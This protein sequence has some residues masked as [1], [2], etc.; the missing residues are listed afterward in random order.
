[1]HDE[2][3]SRWW[4]ISRRLVYVLAVILF[5]A[6]FSE[7]RHAG[8]WLYE[9]WYGFYALYGAAAVIAT[10]GLMRLI[11]RFITRE[12]DRGGSDDA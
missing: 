1:M 3:Q 2:Q 9:G 8:S 7:V 10:T 5:L 4:V 12:T 11:G 6:D